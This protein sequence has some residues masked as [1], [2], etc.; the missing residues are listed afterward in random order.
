LIAVPEYKF[1]VSA[2]RL[3]PIARKCFVA[4]SVV[5]LG[6]IFLRMWRT[7]LHASLPD[8]IGDVLKLL[9]LAA[10]A[11]VVIVAIL[12][13]YLRFKPV[14]ITQHGV[15]GHNV[16]GANVF[17][18]WHRMRKSSIMSMNGVEYLIVA[19]AG[20]ESSPLAIPTVLANW[21]NF[22]EAVRQFAGPDN[23]LSEKLPA[24][25]NTSSE[26]SRDR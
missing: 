25:P 8:F 15:D 7:A 1:R 16:A 6:F 18:P 21:N 20:G 22:A 24:S 26:R 2:R 17:V 11:A 5:F 3:A 9:L 23:A 19:Y 4:F 12:Y 13:C 14:S 10:V